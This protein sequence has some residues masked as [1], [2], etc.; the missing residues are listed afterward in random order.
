MN[1]VQKL[2]FLVVLVPILLFGQQKVGTSIGQFLEIP[3]SPRAEGM[4]GSFIGVADD[5]FTIY[6]NPAGLANQYSKQ[7]AFSHIAWV[8]DINIEYAAF[9][10][11]SMGGVIGI[12]AL[13]F[14]FNELETTPYFPEGTGRTYSAGDLAVAVTY[15]KPLTDRF[16]VGLNFKYVGEYYADI[17][18]HGWA[19]DIGTIYRTAFKDIRLGMMLSNFGPDL[20]LLNQSYPLP[21]NFHFGAAGEIINND[22]HRL[23][24]NFQGSHPND[25]LE[26]FQTGVEY[27]FMEK[28]FLRVG[29]KNHDSER[30]AFGGGFKFA[31]GSL[32]ARADYSFTY[33][34]NLDNVHRVSVYFMF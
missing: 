30:F 23:T 10:M 2:A 12:S 6:Y 34:L 5:I 19:M 13:T 4:G 33:M 25:N 7:F 11:P 32:V 20:T 24:L 26:K 31:F 1:I 17:D 14:S 27:A 21:M 29:F 18:A 8:A 22:N 15:A 16:F 3:P 9:S 28:G